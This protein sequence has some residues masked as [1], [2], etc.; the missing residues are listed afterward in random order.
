MTRPARPARFTG[1][2]SEFNAFLYAPIIE[3]SNGMPLSVLSV[4]A[5]RG[6]D[7]WE[8]AAA[9]ARL[10]DETAAE[11]LAGLI[12][13]LPAGAAER[14]DP[15]PLAAR[16]IA[17]LP[18]GQDRTLVSARPADGSTAAAAQVAHTHGVG[19][20][21][22]Y[23]VLTLFL[24]CSQWIFGGATG[25]SPTPLAQ[26]TTAAATQPANA[27]TPAPPARSGP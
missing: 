14:P 23:L 13:A 11:N 26:P 25:A 20:M 9:W 7:P 5:R 15:G 17:L 21:I 27:Q 8:Q 4:L 12:A 2:S 24:L 22:V 19:F 1:L 6:L 18:Q 10:P 16:L 3:D